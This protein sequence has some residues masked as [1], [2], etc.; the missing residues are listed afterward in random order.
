MDLNIHY[1]LRAPNTLTDDQVR[2]LTEMP[3]A[4]SILRPPTLARSSTLSRF[5]RSI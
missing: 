3:R 1:R 5:F 2:L 4:R